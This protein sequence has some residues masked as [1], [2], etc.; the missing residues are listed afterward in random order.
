MNLFF[1]FSSAL[2]TPIFGL[3][4]LTDKTFFATV[5]QI[6]KTH[7]ITLLFSL[8]FLTSLIFVNSLDKDQR[9][10]IVD[11]LFDCND[12]FEGRELVVAS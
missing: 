8:L 4:N 5:Q 12:R 6:R 2:Q 1:E 7:V 11:L 10:D 3:A 9:N